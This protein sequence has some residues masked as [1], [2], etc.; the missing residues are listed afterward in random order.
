MT[1]LEHW[2]HGSKLDRA[3]DSIKSL[4]L[5]Y[6]ASMTT[7]PENSNHHH[8]VPCLLP[9]HRRP[10]H[11]L[12]LSYSWSHTN[13]IIYLCIRVSLC[14]QEAR[15][16]GHFSFCLSLLLSIQCF[17]VV[18][19]FPIPAFSWHDQRTLPVFYVLRDDF[20]MFFLLLF[21]GPLHWLDHDNTSLVEFLKNL[22]I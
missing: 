17:L 7:I 1:M 18:I 12:Q 10:L 5:N 19:K 13:P 11:A 14:S 15:L 16:S 22:Y 6:L 4:T 9:W 8:C 20:I 3:A 2:C 21:P